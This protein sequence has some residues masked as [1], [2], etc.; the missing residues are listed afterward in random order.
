[1]IDWEK[2]RIRNDDLKAVSGA[3]NVQYEY[4]TIAES[5]YLFGK[6]WFFGSFQEIFLTFHSFIIVFSWFY[7]NHKN[8]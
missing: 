5:L 3:L 4:V 8:R 1:M 6:N 2:K 7:E